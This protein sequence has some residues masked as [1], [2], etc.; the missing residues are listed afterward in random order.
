M[1]FVTFQGNIAIG[2]HKTDGY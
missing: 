2:Y 1:S